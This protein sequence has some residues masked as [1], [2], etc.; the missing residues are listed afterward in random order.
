[1]K[2]GCSLVLDV[3]K[4]NAKMTLWTADGDCLAR[5]VRANEP[6][7]GGP[8]PTLD[9]QGLEAWVKATLKD[10]ATLGRIETIVPV[11]HGAA[12]VLVDQGRLV[13][14]PMDYEADIPAEV[15]DRYRLERDSFAATGSPALPNGLN[16]GAQ[17]AW[18]DTL[19][20]PWL[21]EAQILL[22][23]QYWAWRFSG[24]MASEITSLGC[25]TDL[26]RA[27]EG[28]PSDL[29]RA[30]G[31]AQRLPPLRKAGDMLGPVT[32][33][34][35]REA[36]L[37]PDC[38]VLCGL[39]DS[40][41]ALLA[42]RGHP[43]IAQGDASIVSTGTWFVTMRSLAPDTALA[44]L[45][46]LSEARDC[47]INIDVAQRPAPSCRF[48]GGREAE[49]IAGLDSFHIKDNYDAAAVLAATP[50]LIERGV[51]VLPTFAPG[52][53]PFAHHMGRWIDPPDEPNARR[54]ALGL[55]LALMADACLDLVG[56]RDLILV[57]GRFA[58]AEVFIRALAALRPT[59]SL[60]VS[61][62]QDDVPFGALRLVRPELKPKSALTRVRP[63]AG[64]LDAYKQRWRALIEADCK[65]ARP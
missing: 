58:E 17:L 38:Q 4:T 45:P 32:G 16:L 13:S 28:R 48:M 37:H 20:G 44:S 59:A 29:A 53:G 60:F 47:L 14:E 36:G 42:A 50:E 26:W 40:N 52:F 3:G 43:E 63:L 24:V 34:W 25:H 18:L 1:M 33:E 11:T 23:P 61:N 62:A 39:H 65:R 31:W 27:I 55:Y 19:T 5:R 35:V 46:T 22:W 2:D 54:A 64:S 8:F 30:R 56:A 51:M 15:L 6:Q 10:L 21:D 41:A 7:R 57:E 49:L 9:R 12:A